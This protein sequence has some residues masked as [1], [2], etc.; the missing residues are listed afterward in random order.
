LQSSLER[1]ELERQMLQALNEHANQQLAAQRAHTDALDARVADLQQ[2]WSWRSTAPLR[3][4][5]QVSHLQLWTRCERQLWRWYYALPGLDMTRKRKLI[6]WLH[7]NAPW[8]TRRTLSYQ[9]SARAGAS[10]Q[11]ASFKPRMDEAGAAT[12]MARLGTSLRFSLIMRVHDTAPHRVLAAAESTLRQFY[13]NWDLLIV[14]DA[15]TDAATKAALNQLSLADP[16]IRIRQL[17]R[18]KDVVAARNDALGRVSGDYVAFVEAD[19]ELAR[20][21][22]LAMAQAIAENGADLVYGDEDTVLEDGRHVDPV[23]K[24]DFGLDYLFS[25]NFIGSFFAVRRHLLQAVGEL[26]AD[27]SPFH[28]YDLLLR[29]TEKTTQVAHVAHVLHHRHVDAAMMTERAGSDDSVRTGTAA[30]RESLARRGIPAEVEGGRLP[31]TFRVQRRVAGTPLVSILLPFRDKPDLLRTCVN[32]VIEKTRYANY[33]LIGI[34]NGSADEATHA[35]M[36]ELSARDSRVRFI[37]HDVP[38]NYSAIVNYGVTQTSG[39]HLLML[40][41]DTEVISEEWI[42]ALLEHSQR[43]EVGAVGALLQYPN[44]SI[45]HAGVIVGLGGVAGHA[46]LMLPSRHPGYAGRAQVIQN[47]SAV[48]FAVAMTRRDVFERLGGLDPVNLTA[49][50]NDIDYCLRLRE[51]GYLIVYT[52][53]AE[54]Y[55]HESASRPHDLHPAQRA[56]YDGEIRYMKERHARILEQGDPYYSP[57]LS[58]VQ[59]F[60]PSL[61]YAN[62]LP[63]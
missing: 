16:R 8:L 20:D 43:P 34:D 57:H 27:F 12:L 37:R 19:V 31:D 39:E 53:Y 54:L 44:D 14:D 28:D 61:D 49:A 13:P 23:F 4:V 63:G 60:L 1:A 47:L 56:R 10:A 30:L 46:H 29:L 42:E 22:L 24:P 55:H 59:G 9:L 33:E 5:G 17:K 40:N 6:Q 3:A 35:A 11:A 2:S 32:S 25:T 51:A 7:T 45:Q 50:Y 21:A 15:S 38:F 52:P 58:L 36:R 62:T 18:V 26:R 48:T 41:N